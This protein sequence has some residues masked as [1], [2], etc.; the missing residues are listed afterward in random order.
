M[1]GANLMHPESIAD[2]K[3]S[4]EPASVFNLPGGRISKN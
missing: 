1:S 4:S 2:Q 3:A